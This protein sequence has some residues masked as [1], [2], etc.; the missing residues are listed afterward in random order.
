MAPFSICHIPDDCVDK[1][2]FPLFLARDAL[3]ELIER[4]CQESEG[5][6]TT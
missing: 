5:H 6:K 4:F 2:R 3:R 1:R